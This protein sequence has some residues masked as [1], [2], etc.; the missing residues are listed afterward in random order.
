MPSHPDRVRRHYDP[1]QMRPADI[2]GTTI[3]VDDGVPPEDDNDASDEDSTD[4]RNA[5]GEGRSTF[6]RH[7][8]RGDQERQTA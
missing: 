2:P 1:D 3:D 7:L 4:A 5:H 8:C 6:R